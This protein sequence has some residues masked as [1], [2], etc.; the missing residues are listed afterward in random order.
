MNL[1][2]TL[3]LFSSDFMAPG[4][5]VKSNVKAD[6]SASD[7]AHHDPLGKNPS[8]SDQEQIQWQ[9][10][11]VAERSAGRNLELYEFLSTPVG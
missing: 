9:A 6:S 10:K 1:S 7:I 5:I 2:Q 3:G 11:R 4:A 8:A